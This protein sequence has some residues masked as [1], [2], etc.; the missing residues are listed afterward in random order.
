MKPKAF[1]MEV[2]QLIWF[3]DRKGFQGKAEVAL[4]PRSLSS[5]SQYLFTNSVGQVPYKICDCIQDCG[6]PHEELNR[7]MA[8]IVIF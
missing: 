1:N 6:M 8:F 4:E 3:R 5:W 7:I 2:K